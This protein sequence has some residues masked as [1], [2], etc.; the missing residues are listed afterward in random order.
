MLNILAK[1]K[2]YS[3]SLVNK[4]LKLVFAFFFTIL[5]FWRDLN[6]FFNSPKPEATCSVYGPILG[7]KPGLDFSVGGDMKSRRIEGN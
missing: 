5:P 2:M 3:F 1:D 4:I 7:C 6:S